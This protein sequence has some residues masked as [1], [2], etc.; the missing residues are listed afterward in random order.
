LSKLA[1][2]LCAALLAVAVVT[3]GAPA[4]DADPG[5][6]SG[7]DETFYRLLTEPS[8]TGEPGLTL[9]DFA[10][11]RTQGLIACQRQDNGMDG[12]DAVYTLQS[13]GP[14]SFDVANSIVSAAEVAYC[15]DNL[16]PS[17]GGSGS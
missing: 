16:P 8:S 4:A 13:D 1:S 3:A 12:L 5:A 14:Y 6:Y 17:A 11:V 15:P 9:T 10:L 2:L 7:Q